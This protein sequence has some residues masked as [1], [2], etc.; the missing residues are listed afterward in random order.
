MRCLNTGLCS[1]FLAVTVLAGAA[2]ADFT[3]REREVLNV[4]SG[5]PVSFHD[6][7][8]DRP[9]TGLTARFRFIAPELSAQ[10]ETFGYEALEADLAYLCET[11]AVKRIAAPLPVLIV[12][13][14]SEVPVEFG[15]FDPD[16]TQVFEGYRPDGDT[17]AWE[18]F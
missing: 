16:V 10:L 8:V 14:M 7:I 5:Q 3:P 18:A 11:F 9:A 4:P 15:S 17:C 13:S 12:V 1:T 2:Q 6:S